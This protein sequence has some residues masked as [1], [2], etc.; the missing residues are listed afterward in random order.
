M[1]LFDIITMWPR[2][3]AHCA[4]GH[5]L[6]ELQTKSLAY[7]MRRYAVV[8]GAL[9]SAA[10][11]DEEA[12]VSE[13]GKPVLRRTRALEPERQTATI[14]AYAHCTTCRPVL[15]LARAHWGDEVHEREPWAEWQLEFV[16]GR[17][18]RLVP[19]RLDTRDDVGPALRREGLKILDDDERLACLHFARRAAERG[20][21]PGDE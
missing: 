13:Q 17:L 20:R 5:P 15:Y 19:V 6:A 14:I 9:H 2:G 11:E 8:D 12:V 3:R 16:E 4:E 10:P 18:V 1:G 7:A 21:M